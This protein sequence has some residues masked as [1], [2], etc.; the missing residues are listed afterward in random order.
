MDKI[1]PLIGSD[2]Q[3]YE[4]AKLSGILGKIIDLCT[5]NPAMIN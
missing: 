1:Q 3:L 5:M 4:L 2:F